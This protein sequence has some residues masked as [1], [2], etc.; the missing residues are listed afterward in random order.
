[1]KNKKTKIQSLGFT[2]RHLQILVVAFLLIGSLTLAK[3]GINFKSFFVNADETKQL[4]YEE[5]RNKIY[6]ENPLPTLEDSISAEDSA[7]LALLDRSL[8]QGEV[9]GD[10]IGI[11]TIPPA[12]QIFNREQ[13]DAIKI[14]TQPTNVDTIQKY[15]IDLL[16][17]E[18][19]DEA[20][21]LIGSLNSNDPAVLE[22]AKEQATTVMQKL[23]NVVVPDELADFHRYK[24]IYYQT[25]SGMVDGFASNSKDSNFENSSKIFFSVTNKIE[26]TK[27]EIQTKYNIEL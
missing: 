14:N 21:V 22:K 4:T 25:L 5:V 3:T 9:L 8:D 7:Q 16:G 23:F 20:I 19:Q 18:S 12:D 15:K 26:Q 10:S 11:G 13:L 6:T 2:L 27:A 1:M 24:L 17:V